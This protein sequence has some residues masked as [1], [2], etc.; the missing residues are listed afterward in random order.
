MT[1]SEKKIIELERS[2]LFDT[3]EELDKT[4]KRLGDMYGT[5]RA[6]GLACHFRGLDWVKMLVSNG[7]VFK[8]ERMQLFPS[9]CYMSRRGDH[10]FSI[11][12]SF[13][14]CLLDLKIL[15]RSMLPQLLD[16]GETEPKDRLFAFEGEADAISEEDRLECARYFIELNNSEICDLQELLFNA[17]EYSDFKVTEL[18]RENGI[19]ISQSTR[20]MMLT[21]DQA[22]QSRFF[23]NTKYMRAGEFVQ[24]VTELSKDLG[25]NRVIGGYIRDIEGLKDKLIREH[26]PEA[27][28]C[29][30]THFDIKRISQKKI[31]QEIILSGSPAL[32]AV[33]EK[34][35]WLKMPKKRDE[36][37][38]FAADNDMTECAAWLLDF[39]KRTSDPAAER[40]KAEKKLQRELNADPYSI[41]EMKKSWGFKKRGDG[42]IVITRYKGKR[43]E[44][45]VPEKIGRDIVREIGKQAFSPNAL[46]LTDEQREFRKSITKIT[47][48]KTLEAIRDGAFYGCQALSEINIPSSVK[49]IEENAFRNCLKL[50]RAELPEGILEISSNCFLNC[51]ALKKIVIPTTVK[52]IGKWAFMQCIYAEETVIPKNV[53]EI[54]KSAFRGCRSTVCADLPKSLRELGDNCFVDCR[55]LKK[56]TIPPDVKK[57]GDG[58][59]RDCGSLEEIFISEGVGEIGTLSFCNCLRL[60]KIN[61]PLSVK[62]IGKSAFSGCEHLTVTVPEGSYAKEY[63]KEN[64]IQYIV[65]EEK[66]D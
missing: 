45:I 46:R 51:Y 40:E 37:I 64:N 29:F 18:L 47:L 16:E 26:E 3:P 1:E 31:M 5:S 8:C 9:L 10:Y 49:K 58:A 17:I 32:L 42:G 24:A 48:P 43:D 23:L 39:K 61:I 11:N 35:G 19:A 50:T 38:Q 28:E 44:V 20:E 60:L 2:V 54:Q 12:D 13:M 41:T 30:L 55:A 59:F 14:F 33:C 27:F 7:F 34:L 21:G 56:I 65:L 62:K 63:C 25:E 22:N 15:L 4:C 36:M 57:I 53:E 52:R 66:N 6:L